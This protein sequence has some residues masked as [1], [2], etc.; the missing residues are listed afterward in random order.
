MRRLF[1]RFAVVFGVI[2]V[3]FAATAPNAAAATLPPV[4]FTPKPNFGVIDGVLDR[5]DAALVQIAARIERI[6]QVDF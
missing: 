3:G 5:T 2:G 4:R 6:R 1:V